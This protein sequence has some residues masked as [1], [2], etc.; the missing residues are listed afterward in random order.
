[1]KAG[2]IA[3]IIEELAPGLFRRAGTTQALLLAVPAGR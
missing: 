3:A 1:M 2:E